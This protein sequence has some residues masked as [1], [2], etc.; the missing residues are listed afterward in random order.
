MSTRFY[1]LLLLFFSLLVSA[2]S[3][4]QAKDFHGDSIYQIFTDRFS[5]GDKTNDDPKI[6]S[7][8]FDPARKNW[9]AYWGGD[10]KGVIDKLPYIKKLGFT[11][12]WI[13][14]VVD[15]VNKPTIDG[16]GTVMAPYHGYHA[17]DFK[18]IEEHIGDWKVFDN[19]IKAAHDN[20]LKVMIDMPL[21]HTSAI[22][23]GEFGALYD[24][25]EF[26]SDT[27]N[28]RNKLFHHL[29]EITDWNDPYQL[30]Y[31]TLAWL[32]DLNQE[33][34]Y[35]DTY[36]SNALLKFEK[37]GADA[38][39]LDAAKHANWGWQQTIVNKLASQD[40]HFVAAEWWMSDSL[41][42]IYKQGAK[43][44]N[45]AGIGM[46]DFP[47]ST[48]MRKIF[49]SKEGASFKVLAREI[50]NEYKDV[51][52][53]NGLITFIDNHDMPRLLSL[54]DDKNS[55]HIAIALLMTSR[56]IPSFYYGTEQYLHDDTKC[57]VD[58]YTRVY[59]SSFDENTPAF[60]LVSLLNGLRAK[61]QA[62][63]SGVQSTIYVSRDQYVYKREFGGDLAIVAV[64]KSADKDF[65]LQDLGTH[66][67]KGSY[68][69]Q[70]QG[71]LSGVDLVMDK[72]NQPQSLKLP[73]GSVSVWSLKALKDKDPAIASVMPSVIQGG[74]PVT[75]TGTGFG[76]AVGNVY[77][78]GQSLR[79]DHWSDTK[80][81][82]NAPGQSTGA[83]KLF[84]ERA[85]KT[86]SKS[87]PFTVLENKLVPIT[88][89]VKSAPFTLKGEELYISGETV[90]LGE[91]R[92]TA[93]HAAGPMLL[94]EDRDYILCV[95]MPAG[96]EVKFK[97]LIMDKTGKVMNQESIVH[98]YRVPAQGPWRHKLDWQQ[99]DN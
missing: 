67:P 23:H 8:M 98:T 2:N 37:H 82:F 32:G 3:E 47:F 30:Q 65:T 17:R 87:K 35:I 55:L 89:V 77:F 95:P 76:S 54:K 48:A 29:P 41:D 69:D 74:V 33:S 72:D 79:V 96:K 43:F 60:Q 70:L 1:P 50:E 31:Y 56:G 4:A 68:K 92:K 71:K 84:V 86:R 97:L 6:S 44:V 25:T 46:F 40:K 7:G 24:G 61:S 58:P 39:R 16:E 78:S 13:S 26:M 75:I 9:H 51:D 90:G 99:V 19:L 28:D 11:A 20:G 36:L 91:W 15:N 34:S 80:I 10:L 22:N 93:E 49:G 94:S 45:K 88:F 81:V 66:V 53:C 42:P 38:T 63:T 12:I 52:D 27:E 62:L 14:P 21:N 64:N 73:P 57:G 59:M 85:D 83:D 5:N 18:G